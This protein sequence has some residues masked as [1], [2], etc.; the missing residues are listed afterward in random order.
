MK[1]VLDSLHFYWKSLFH[2]AKTR[3]IAIDHSCERDE[4]KALEFHPQTK[5]FSPLSPRDSIL[6]NKDDLV[7][8]SLDSSELFYG[9]IEGLP[10]S[11]D[12]QLFH[13]NER[14]EGQIAQ[15]VLWDL[16]PYSYLYEFR[17]I[18]AKKTDLHFVLSSKKHLNECKAKW[19]QKSIFPSI[20]TT[21]FSALVHYLQFE[22]VPFPCIVLLKKKNRI[23]KYEFENPQD[24]TYSIMEEMDL[25]SFGEQK[26][27]EK[28]IVSDFASPIF[29]SDLYDPDLFMKGLCLTS[30][31]PLQKWSSDS[32][33]KQ[34]HTLLPLT[35]PSG[36]KFKKGVYNCL[37]VVVFFSCRQVF[38]ILS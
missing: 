12:N 33:I 14:I 8:A 10:I 19:N 18:D 4:L 23:E 6:E 32:W 5:L 3:I 17:K 37:G 24:I 38:F 31:S 27:S 21:S 29:E 35:I 22:K 28:F 11:V 26:G 36:K 2:A 25:F 34:L 7:I 1:K 16:S 15:K 9:K 13:R 20:I 30:Q